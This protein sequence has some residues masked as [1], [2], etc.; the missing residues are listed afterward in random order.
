MSAKAEMCVALQHRDSVRLVTFNFRSAALFSL[1]Q[2]KASVQLFLFRA[3]SMRRMSEKR[4]ISTSFCTKP[5]L[6]A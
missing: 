5:V 4:S 1:H 2:A 6:S 3:S